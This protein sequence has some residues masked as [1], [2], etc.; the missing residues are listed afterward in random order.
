M[1]EK[2]KPSGIDW[3]GDVPNEWDI[4]KVKY[5]TSQIGSGTTPDSGNPLYY[6]D[7]CFPW[8]QSGDLYNADYIRNTEKKITE[9]AVADFNA[10]T[11]Y[12]KEFVVVAMYGASVG[13]IAISQISS[14]TNQA[15]CVLKAKD[16]DLR[17]LFYFLSAGK[18]NMLQMAFG[19][20]QPNISQAIIKNLPY[21]DVSHNEQ[22]A[23]ADFLDKECAQ[24]DSIAA[25][26]EKQ[27][28]LLQQYKKSLITETV[29]KGLDKSAPMKD[30]EVEWIGKIPEHW[31]AKRLKYVMNNFDAQRKPIEAQNRSQD[32]EILY[33]YY[34]ASGAID[35][36]D[37][38][39][40]DETSILIGED[41]ANLV[42]RNLPLIYIATGKYWVNNHAHILRPKSESDLYYMAYQ[43]EIIDYSQFITGSAQPKLSQENLNNVFLVVP[44]LNEQRRIASY[45]EEKISC[46]DTIVRK[47]QEQL[48]T[49]QQHK[50]SLI[51]EYV[52]GKKRVKE[53]Q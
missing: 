20:T 53:V 4:T 2:M 41:G 1:A 52:T 50:K 17:Y 29:T 31:K 38:Y 14:Y 36:I 16:D 22:Q 39:I 13:N 21:L 23:I 3:I 25:D 15:C 33:D 30:S 47:K 7:G 44:P 32:G 43:M 18:E 49:I 48:S 42:L 37:D 45:L 10:L 12:E 27:I 40:F 8:I 51:Y 28:A 35:K 26:L 24:I 11:W 9:L 19:G 5:R 6:E 46:I 34:G